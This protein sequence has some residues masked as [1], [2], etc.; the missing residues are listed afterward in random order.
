VAAVFDV[1]D[2]YNVVAV[3]PVV[4]PGTDRIEGIT[5]LRSPAGEPTGLIAS[6]EGN[7]KVSITTSAPLAEGSAFK[8]QLFHLA[9]QEGNISALDDAPRLSG[10][11]NALR[12]QDIDLDGIPGFTNTLTLSS[13]DAWIPGLFYGASAQA[14]GAVGRGDVLIQNALGVQAIALGNHEFDQGTAALKGLIGGDATAGFAGTAFPYLSG[15]L[16]FATDATWPA[17]WCPMARLPRP[18]ASPAAWCLT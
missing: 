2:P 6:S 4:F 18:T 15:N 3:D 9:D 8:L 5:F 7:D 10:V 13:G 14:Y 17:W 16:N 11:L 1:S 12:A